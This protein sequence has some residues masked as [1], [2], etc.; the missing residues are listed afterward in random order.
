MEYVK[1]NNLIIISVGLIFLYV[2][3]KS[4]NSQ[5]SVIS[6]KP[7]AQPSILKDSTKE[8]EVVVV[9]KREEDPPKKK[10]RER[11]EEV[12]VVKKREREESKKSPK[13][14]DIP[15]ISSKR[16]SE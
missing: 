8:K 13:K 14:D 7:S 16:S 1:G 6:T 11:E 10:D 4:G 2:A 9:K 3:Y 5:T 15:Y 12:V